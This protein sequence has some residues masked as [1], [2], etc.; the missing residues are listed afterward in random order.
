VVVV[1]VVVDM[2][3]KANSKCLVGNGVQDWNDKA[4]LTH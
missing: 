1:V 3:V 4:A 2:K